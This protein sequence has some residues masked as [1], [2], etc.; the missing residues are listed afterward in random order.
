M[1]AVD[2]LLH[3]IS[4]NL[5]HASTTF[6]IGTGFVVL[7]VLAVISHVLKQLLFKNPREP[8]LVFSWFPLVGSTITYGIDPYKFFFACREKVGISDQIR[9]SKCC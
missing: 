4:T 7:C 1:D 5:P 2:V 3:R 9:K 6:I 8:P